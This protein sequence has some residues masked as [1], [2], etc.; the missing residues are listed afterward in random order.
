MYVQ[1][2]WRV[3]KKLTLN[4]GFR[5]SMNIAPM[6]VDD[7][8]SDFSPT[9]PNPGAGGIPGATIF[10]GNGQGRIGRRNI[11]DN[12]YGGYE[13]RF[14]FAYAVNS[15]TTVR[16]A[17]TRSFG[18]VAGIGQ[19]SHNLGFAVRLTV[20]TNPSGGLTPLWVLKDG[21]PAWPTPPTID[22]SVGIGTNPPAY[23]G[24]QANRPDSELNYTFNIQRQITRSSVLEV[25]YLG[26]LASDITSNFLALNQVPYRLLPA[27]LSPFTNAGRT[28]LGSVVG[29]AAAIAAGVTG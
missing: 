22:P 20:S 7:K 9:T 12:W 2:D 11:I 14:G 29:S 19:S 25:G 3:S 13:P 24:N 10:V 27:S 8:I 6:S 16:G 28:A 4:L 1:D 15:K 23:A 21:A 5:Y 18:P 26:T 17:A